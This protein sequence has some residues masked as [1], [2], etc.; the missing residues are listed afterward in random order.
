MLSYGRPLEMVARRRAMTAVAHSPAKCRPQGPRKPCAIIPPRRASLVEATGIEPAS[1][2]CKTGALPL[3]YAP[4]D[5][6]VRPLVIVSRGAPGRNRTCDLRIKSPLLYQL[7]YGGEWCGRWDSNPHGTKSRQGLSLPRLP[8]STTPAWSGA[9]TFP[10]HPVACASLTPFGPPRLGTCPAGRTSQA[11][12]RLVWGRER[13]PMGR[14]VT[15]LVP[16]RCRPG[17]FHPPLPLEASPGGHRPVGAVCKLGTA[18]R[19]GV[20]GG[21]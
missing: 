17:D 14:R 9:P 21:I 18:R 8:S 3:S 15:C 10:S 1:P 13:P 16:D 19:H 11:F 7:S 4:E 20:R 6:H 5:F 12:R 2:V